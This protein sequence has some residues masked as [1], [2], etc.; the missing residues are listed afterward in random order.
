MSD[1]KSQTSSQE[2]TSPEA[3]SYV[4]EFKT[5][6]TLDKDDKNSK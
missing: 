5:D 6:I 2:Q 3:T 4:P 1:T